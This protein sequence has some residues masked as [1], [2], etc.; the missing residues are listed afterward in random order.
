MK[1][2]IRI[3]SNARYNRT[4]AVDIGRSCS[5]DPVDEISIKY[6]WLSKTLSLRSQQHKCKI[7]YGKQQ[8]INDITDK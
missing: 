5:N 4:V 6:K 8:H 1:Y 3:I 2:H 7:Q